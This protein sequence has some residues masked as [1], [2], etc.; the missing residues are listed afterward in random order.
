MK[1]PLIWAVAAWSG[2]WA[3]AVAQDSEPL[4][5]SLRE[6]VEQALVSNLD[7]AL[8]RLN[9]PEARSRSLDARGTFDPRARL[10]LGYG[11][12]VRPRNAEQVAATALR[13]VE[14][15]RTTGSGELEFRSAAGTT[16]T[17]ATSVSNT[18]DTFNNF[19]DEF[20][21]SAGLTL[22]QPLLKNFG[23]DVN[24]SALRSA[25]IG[26]T[27]AF[28]EFM[29]RAETIVRDVHYA[30]YELLYARADHEARRLSLELARQLLHDNEERL[31]LG[32]VAPLDVS[33]ARA[34]VATRESE[35]LTSEGVVLENENALKRLISRDL[36]SLL[37]RRLDPTDGLKEPAGA[38]PVFEII[39][40]GLEK[41]R[42]YLAALKAAEQDDLDILFTRN[43]LLPQLDLSASYTVNGLSNSLERSYRRA[44]KADGEEWF[45]GL[46]LEF[47]W[48]SRSERARIEQASLAKARSLLQIKNLEQSI[49]AAIDNSTNQRRL[50]A[51]KVTT[52]KV[53]REA[54]EENLR[55]EEEKLRA[56]AS[57]TYT[58]L[59]LQRDLANART[60]ELRA[61]ADY[62]RSV[63]QLLQSQGILLETN[64]IR[65]D[66]P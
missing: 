59:Q 12:V 26:E 47:P 17:G 10:R 45:I 14:S 29:H 43:Q 9:T 1:Q 31:K 37:G 56:G 58:L 19:E 28:D 55:A 30:Y 42:D 6:A 54:A 48:G 39:R 11:E 57:T 13:K 21:T 38:P 20:D 5:L 60:R 34:E 18:E 25:R 50:N 7:L 66:P 33:Q 64:G 41:R 24:L 2:L 32:A 27:I 22:R 52:A 44:S 16:L 46:T 3:V 62:N 8:E 15:E 65:V 51:E 49:I 23:T 4:R 61:L 36:G 35:L 53:A 40:T 63:V